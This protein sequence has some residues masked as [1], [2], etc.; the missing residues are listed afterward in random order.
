[1]AKKTVRDIDL[2]GKKVIMRADFNVPL[3]NERRITDTTRIDK[4]LPTINYILE[5]GASLILMSHLGRPKGEVKAEFSL[6][7]VAAELTEKI[8]REVAMASDCIGPEVVKAA[9]DLAPGAVLL[10]ENLR[11]HSEETANES[12]FAK[13]LAELAN[14]YVN[15]AFGTAH[16]AHA[17]TAGI[18]EFMEVCV[19]GFLLEKEIKFLGDAVTAP[20]RPLVAI[21]GGAKV[22]SKIGVIY[23]L[24]DKADSIIIGGGM[25]YTFYKAQ[26]KEIGESLFVEEDLAVAE[27]LIKQAAAKGVE[28]VLPVDSKAIDADVGDLFADPSKA[29]S[30][31]LKVFNNGIEAGWSGVDIGPETVDKIC[32]VLDKAKTVVWNGP[33]G[34]FEIK[35]FAVGTT[36]VA[37][38]LAEIDAMTII[39][40]GDSVAAVNQFGLAEKMTHVSTGGGASLEFLEGKELPGVAALDD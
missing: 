20:E 17:S 34:V 15:D 16:R 7:P 32:A 40:G 1:M 25:T 37:K 14:V 11:F 24:L 18:T 12:G 8:G 3:D 33:M 39:G 30:V 26:G 4:A 5:Q 27:D 23:N 31:N 21:L 6:A 29:A 22:S 9:A 13:Q 38:K 10:L 36:A 2:K 28:L 19:S 35:E